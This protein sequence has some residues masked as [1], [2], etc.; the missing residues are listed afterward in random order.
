MI[1]HSVSP[2]RWI[3]GGAILG[4][5]I[6][7]LPAGAGAGEKTLVVGAAGFPESLNPGI[8]SFS[9]LSLAYQT[10]DP[11]VHRDDAGN[12]IPGLATRWQAI[13]SLSWRFHLR[14][15]VR[16]HD[17]TEFTS[18]DVKYTLD[19][20]L[21]PKTVYGTK[22]RIGLIDKT[23]AVDKYIV[24]IK[25]KKP[26]PTLANGLSDIPIHPKLYLEKVGPTGFS[27]HPVG[28]GPFKFDKWTPGDRYE[29]VANK[30]YWGGAPKV[31]KLLIRQIPEN[32]TRVASLLAGETH[33]IEEVPVDLLPKIE[34][35]GT[36]KVLSVESTVGLILTMDTR[37]PPFDNPKVRLALDYAIDKP[38]ILQQMLKNQGALLQGQL[39]TANTFG[40]HPG[41]KPRPY[42]SAKAR[43]LL[44]EA[45]YERGFETSITTRS[46]KYLSDVEICNA[47]AGMLSQVGIKTVVNVV[48]GGVYLKMATA[49]E[50]GPIHMV[51]WYSLGDADFATVW[52]TEG[53]KRTLWNNAEFEKLFIE[54]R[55]TVDSAKRVKIYHRMMEIMHE[56]NPSIFL[57]GL[58]SI[59]AVSKRV[60][61]F[62]APPDK[63]LRLSKV[64]LQ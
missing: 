59:A 50:I 62:N 9:A 52:F 32:T 27:K 4:A 23:T 14:Q 43:Q 12:L 46:G 29:L 5:V 47:V 35:S 53:G 3:L 42:D 44:K 41:L 6:M 7:L 26:F 11:L 19:Y 1:R 18:Q 49:R 25:T 48:E 8:S 10:M 36:A 31:D 57:F 24:E 2:L 55:T 64:A 51:G 15:G 28:T 45:G 60:S 37:K 17:G 20:I 33:I 21:D 56:E 63:V 58:P 54:G 39:L 38:L 16:F 34:S 40:F 30:D 22:E 61:G 13:D